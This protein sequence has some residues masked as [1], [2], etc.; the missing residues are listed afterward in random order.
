MGCVEFSFLLAIAPCEYFHLIPYNPFAMTKKIAIAIVP[1]K[2]TLK[3]NTK[4]RYSDMVARK[5]LVGDA[6]R[7]E[8]RKS[9]L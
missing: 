5:R 4:E 8:P 7:D 6:L 1:C 3:Y 2:Q 9:I